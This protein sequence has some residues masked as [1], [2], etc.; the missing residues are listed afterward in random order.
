MTISKVKGEY[1]LWTYRGVPVARALVPGS[2]SRANSS[3]SMSG[4]GKESHYRPAWGMPGKLG[5]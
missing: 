3:S 1:Y 2:C 5:S 4:L